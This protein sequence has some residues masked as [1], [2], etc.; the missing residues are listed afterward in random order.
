MVLLISIVSFGFVGAAAA[1]SRF[2]PYQTP[3]L[4]CGSVNLLFTGL[5]AYH[6][7]VTQQG[8]DP[9]LI[10][11]AVRADSASLL[12][13]GYNVRVVLM[14]PEQNISVL[15]NRI[16]GTNWNGVGVGN[17]VRSAGLPELI[18][19]FEDILQLYHERVPRAPVLFNYISNSTLF[20]WAAQRHFP[21]ANNCTN[22]PGKDLGFEVYCD[23]CAQ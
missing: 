4:A 1:A 22:S 7:L 3:K 8:F 15:A 18:V 13:A 17:G 9:A 14:G 5:P 2:A 20:L 23:I 10:D 11:A 19:R 16:P 12:K 21:L 6:P